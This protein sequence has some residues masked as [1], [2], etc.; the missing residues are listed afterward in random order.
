MRY[1]EK[2]GGNIRGELHKGFKGEEKRGER[3]G[4]RRRREEKE[5]KHFKSR[6]SSL[7]S[8]HI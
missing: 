1:D 4:G 7:F 8:M 5:F 6:F 2:E 3:K